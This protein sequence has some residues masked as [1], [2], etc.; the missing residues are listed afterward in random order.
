MYV[1]LWRH[2]PGGVALRALQSLVLFALVVAALFAWVFPR[3]E[4]DL[5]YQDV[6][7]PGPSATGT[8]TP[9]TATPGTATP[10]TATPTP[11]GAP[12]ELPAG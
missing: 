1:W 9:G 4:A 2:L 6:T 10:G 5:P 3:L 7:V 12:T 11:G 8:A